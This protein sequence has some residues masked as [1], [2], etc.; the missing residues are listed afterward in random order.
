MGL[1]S[2]KPKAPAF[3]AFVAEAV[4]IVGSQPK[5]ASRIGCSQQQIDRLLNRAAKISPEHAIGIHV[6]TQGRVP[7]SKM[8]PDLWRCPEDVPVERF[9]RVLA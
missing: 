6:A 9:E 7:A 5:L 4:E 1:F 8:R 2:R 3:R